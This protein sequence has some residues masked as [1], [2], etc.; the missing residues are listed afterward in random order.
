MWPIDFNSIRENCICI[1]VHN[2]NQ[3]AK[4]H[5]LRSFIA[6]AGKCAFKNIMIVLFF[7]LVSGS[8][9]IKLK[10]KSEASMQNFSRYVIAAMLVDGKQKIA[11]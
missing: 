3:I 4:P 1:Y 2:F 10:T 8:A 6:L 5:Y 7:C 11:H 9:I